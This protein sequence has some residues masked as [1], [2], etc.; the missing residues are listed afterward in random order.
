MSARTKARKRQTAARV[1]G[2]QVSVKSFDAQDGC[3]EDWFT[4]KLFKCYPKTAMVSLGRKRIA[5]VELQLSNANWE[6][7][8]FCLAGNIVTPHGR[9]NIEFDGNLSIGA[10]DNLIE[11]LILLRERANAVGMLTARATPRSVEEVLRAE[12]ITTPRLA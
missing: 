2:V 4:P 10:I 6:Q 8:E 7:T 1:G 11:A 9:S 5:H 12:A 3:A